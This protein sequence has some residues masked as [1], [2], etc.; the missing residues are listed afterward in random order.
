MDETRATSK[1]VNACFT[2]SHTHKI[3]RAFLLHACVL[4]SVR[5]LKFPHLYSSIYT[6]HL[7][8][9]QAKK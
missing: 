3:L 5:S 7:Y 4:H 8:S 9:F 1:C 6:K 2:A